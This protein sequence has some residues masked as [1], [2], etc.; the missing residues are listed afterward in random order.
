MAF[1]DKLFNTNFLEYASY[2]IKDRAIPDLTD[3]LKPVQRRILHSLF[4]MDDGKFH[5][6][7][8]IVGHCM[9]YHPHGDA[10]IYSA[11]VNIAQKDLFIDKQG[12]FGNIFTG[13]EASAARYIEARLT[14]LAK[15]IFY[16]P[17]ITE[18][19][20]SYDG[21]NQEP[22]LFP[23]KL[24]VVLL[25][26]IDG[27]A[28][29]MATKILPHNFH[30]VVR[31]VKAALRGEEFQLLPDF[32]TAGMMDAS[33]YADGNGTVLVRAKLD[34]S[35]EKRIVI[36]E[37][38]YGAT[39]ETIIDSI[40]SAAK[41]GK[42]K[43][44]GI[45]DFTSE[46]VEIEIKLPRGVYTKEV[47]DAL[48]AF[49]QCQISHSVNLL[50]IHDR[51]PVQMTVTEVIRHHAD[52][53]VQVLTKELE[54]EKRQLFD[55]L[56]ARTLERIFI[57][58][59][60]YKRIEEEKTKEGVVTAVRT[61]FEP[62]KKELL[63]PISDED[64]ERLLQIPIRRISLYDINKAR[65]EI[66][67]IKKR[68]KEIDHHLKHIVAY[69]LDHLDALAKKAPVDDKRLT[70]PMSFKK[71]EAR[72]VALKDRKLRWD[73]AT[74]YL[75]TE[76]A[77]GELLLEVSALD[78]IVLFD[79][80]AA[81]RVIN[82]PEKLF[83]GKNNLLWAGLADKEELAKVTFSL[84]LKNPE[85]NTA[86]IKRFKIE[87]FILEKEYPTVPD[88]LTLLKLTTKTKVHIALDYKQKSLIRVLEETFPLEK[89]LVKNRDAG[90]VRVSPKEIN[91]AKFVRPPKGGDEGAEDL[92]EALD[93]E[94]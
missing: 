36:R 25:Q 88:G 75:G 45:S 28:V 90:G 64:I 29:G 59:R 38:P 73:K 50:V 40:E 71:I 48:Y 77:T 32:P 69:A 84:L 86:H 54:L 78:R 58:E 2:V 92:D 20:D 56:H 65:Q 16:N 91:S 43:I 44:A 93:G 9:K 37:L 94:D 31:A 21:R 60:I 18:Y 14:P 26:G 89:F 70:V 10:S 55:K 62:F 27:I 12:N 33:A 53:L 52:Q 8:N 51:R 35:D 19:A 3:G 85:A 82:V 15:E 57:E 4:E 79:K 7:A 17:Q 87:G 30:E 34:T 83:L 1:V 81:F 67:E 47:V 24:P 13:D 80:A 72:D 63:R 5:K 74:G 39:T 68:I 41:K 11:L 49:T 66:E 46:K 61:G 76:V 23:A 6:V 42:I 22:L